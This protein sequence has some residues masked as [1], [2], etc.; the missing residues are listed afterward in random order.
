MKKVLI[1]L[2]IMFG[3]FNKGNSAYEKLAYDFK[4]NGFI[5]R[6]K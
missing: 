3:F 6:F 2:I 5:F 4:F 1:I